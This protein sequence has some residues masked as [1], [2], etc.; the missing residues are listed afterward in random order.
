MKKV[1]LKKNL[2]EKNSNKLNELRIYSW[3]YQSPT[4][5]VQKSNTISGD[6]E[7]ECLILPFLNL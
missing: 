1:T 3:G 7:S 6:W 2:K 5:E 4:Y